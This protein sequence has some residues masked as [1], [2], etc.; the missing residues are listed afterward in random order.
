MGEGHRIM[1][2]AIRVHDIAVWLYYLI[3]GFGSIT[4]QHQV[5]QLVTFAKSLLL[6]IIKDISKFYG[7]GSLAKSRA[8]YL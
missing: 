6:I 2:H 4:S 5:S 1:Y 3:T 8:Q 7:T